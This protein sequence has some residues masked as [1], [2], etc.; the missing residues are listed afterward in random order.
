MR[1]HVELRDQSLA[2]RARGEP[3]RLGF[4]QSAFTIHDLAD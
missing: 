2:L 3:P 1:G 4:R